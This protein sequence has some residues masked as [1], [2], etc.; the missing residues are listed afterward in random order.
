M[1]DLESRLRAELR[2]ERYALDLPS[3]SV[4]GELDGRLR[5][6]DRAGRWLLA[7]AASAVLV[8]AVVAV[9][10]VMTRGGAPETPA[11]PG[12]DP[13]STSTTTA[14]GSS[15]AGGPTSG[16]LPAGGPEVRG[17]PPYLRR[18]A[19]AAAAIR[20]EPRL[21]VMPASGTPAVFER[22]GDG[23]VT[24]VVVVADP[25]PE[26]GLPGS[27]Q[28]AP[29]ATAAALG[30]IMALVTDH[31]ASSTTYVMSFSPSGKRWFVAVT[32]AAPADRLAAT[33]AVVAG[34]L[35]GT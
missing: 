25:E 24:R 3:D 12:S 7:S 11:G 33:Q 35:P 10:A 16:S 19:D 20:A 5:H 14:D 28:D 18:A 32:A 9:F 8:L 22:A 27:R 1:T 34:T 30:G 21:A 29:W 13:V 26:V 15:P 31:E 4:I 23:P 2:S 17:V 6:G